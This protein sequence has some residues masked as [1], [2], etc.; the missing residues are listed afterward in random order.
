VMTGKIK[1]LSPRSLS[2]PEREGFR[3]RI[4]GRKPLAFG[5]THQCRRDENCQILRKKGIMLL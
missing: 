5:L 4:I 3:G 1:P 2:F